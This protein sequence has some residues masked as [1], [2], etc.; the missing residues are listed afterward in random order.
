MKLLRKELSPTGV[1][2]KGSVQSEYQALPYLGVSTGDAVDRWFSYWIQGCPP[3]AQQ[4]FPH[5]YRWAA[6]PLCLNYYFIQA[7]R[8]SGRAGVKRWS[9]NGRTAR[10]LHNAKFTESINSI[11]GTKLKISPLNL[12]ESIYLNKPTYVK[13]IDSIYFDLEHDTNDAINAWF[14]VM[15]NMADEQIYSSGNKLETID[16]AYLKDLGE[17]N[18]RKLIKRKQAILLYSLFNYLYILI[19]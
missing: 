4:L 11:Y 13:A 14:N 17:T 16:P 7:S 2:L 3:R 15:L 10:L 6:L 5:Q 1:F 18:K 8:A 12:S 19:L 9:A